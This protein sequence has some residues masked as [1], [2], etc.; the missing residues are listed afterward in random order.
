MSFEITEDEISGNLEFLATMDLDQ[1]SIDALND[2]AI[3]VETAAKTNA[4]WQDITGEARENLSVE[5]GAEGKTIV[6]TL[7]HGV[8]YGYWLETIQS[9]YYAIIMPTLEEYSSQIMQTVGAH[10]TGVETSY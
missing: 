3:E 7:M 4:P 9:G 2:I 8:D 10:V 6:L 5:L 1:A